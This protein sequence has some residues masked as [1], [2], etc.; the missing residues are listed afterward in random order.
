MDDDNEQP[1]KYNRSH[2]KE[3]NIHVTF[4]PDIHANVGKSKHEDMQIV[5]VSD[6]KEKRN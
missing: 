1:V 2:G 5:V 4:I 3:E 6:E